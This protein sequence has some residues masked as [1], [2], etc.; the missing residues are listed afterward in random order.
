MRVETNLNF[1]IYL[2]IGLVLVLSLAKSPIPIKI[3]KRMLALMLAVIMP[4]FIPGHGEIVMLIPNAA[5]YSVASTEIKVLAVIFTLVNYFIACF[6]LYKV[7][8]LFKS[9][10]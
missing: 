7:F 1:I 3:Y 8:S 10:G 6:F 5:M 4:S 9:E 2:I